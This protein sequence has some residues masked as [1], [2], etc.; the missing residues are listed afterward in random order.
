MPSRNYIRIALLIL[1]I[2]AFALYGIAAEKKDKAVHE[3]ATAKARRDAARAV[4]EGTWQRCR[5][6]PNSVSFEGGSFRD[7]SVRWMQAERDL[8]QKK[9]DE[10]TALEEHVKRMQ[11]WKETL[12]DYVKGQL[13]PP[14]AA[15][16]AEF[17]RL[18]AE[19][20]LTAAKAEGK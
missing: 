3:M 12:D 14:Y 15:S 17:F 13:A 16:A 19:E 20:W 1:G 9:A 7:W 10:I 2:A 8:S 18:E 6:D 5:V 4:Y 11:F